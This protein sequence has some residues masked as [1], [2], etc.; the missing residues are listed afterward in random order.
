MER[1]KVK[2]RAAAGGGGGEGGG[3]VLGLARPHKTPLLQKKYN[4]CDITHVSKRKQK[5]VQSSGF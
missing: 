5:N 1:N 3:A 4:K 2:G